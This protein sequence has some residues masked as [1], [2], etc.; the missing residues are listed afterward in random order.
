MPIGEAGF[1]EALFTRLKARRLE[2]A[3]AEGVPAYVIFHNSTLESLT[4]LR[5]KS[6]DEARRISG[7]SDGKVSRYLEP[8]LQVIREHSGG[9]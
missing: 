9:D 5:P 2:L 4:R 8:F 7:I 1:D 3:R 6:A